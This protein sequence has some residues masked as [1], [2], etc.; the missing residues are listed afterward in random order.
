MGQVGKGDPLVNSPYSH[1]SGF[2]R[3]FYYKSL[4]CMFCHEVQENIDSQLD[5]FEINSFHSIFYEL[6]AE[7]LNNK[8]I[9]KQSI[10]LLCNIDC[11]IH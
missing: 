11:T 9:K 10:A 8:E 5:F 6:R 1:T 2:I 7:V 4:Q 3:L